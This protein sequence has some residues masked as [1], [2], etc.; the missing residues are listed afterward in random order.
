MLELGGGLY[1]RVRNKGCVKIRLDGIL[2]LKSAHLS[3][4]LR[5]GK[6]DLE[7]KEKILG[8]R[9]WVKKL[10]FALYEVY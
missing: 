7:Y 6:Y 8:L 1:I 10:S 5:L 4:R 9:F 3:E 2:T